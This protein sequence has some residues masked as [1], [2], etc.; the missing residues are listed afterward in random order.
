MGRYLQEQLGA[1]LKLPT[2][3]IDRDRPFGTMGL[4]SLMALEFTRRVNAGLGTTLPAT[5]AF[6]Y[7]S[8]RQFS[9]LLLGKLG[10]AEE[11]TVEESIRPPAIGASFSS[12]AINKLS[13]DEALRELIEADGG[14]HER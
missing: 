13:E 7:P 4:D 11:S 6:N 5:A 14:A 2:E 10:F 3:R 1:V 8:V 12:T 9:T